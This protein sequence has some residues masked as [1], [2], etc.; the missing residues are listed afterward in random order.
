MS[1]IKI[2]K[3][4]VETEE[5]LRAKLRAMIAAESIQISFSNGTL[6]WGDSTMLDQPE[7]T[8]EQIA[9]FRIA[10]KKYQAEAAQRQAEALE[11][12]RLIEEAEAAEAEED[13]K[14]LEASWAS[15]DWWA[16]NRCTCTM[17]EVDSLPMNSDIPCL[18]YKRVHL[19]EDGEPEEC[20]FFNSPAGCRDGEHCVYQH[21]TRNPAEMPCRFES[22]SAGCNPGFG[23]KCPYMH[24]KPIVEASE[25]AMCRFDT[26][27]KPSAGKTCPFKH[28]NTAH[29]HEDGWTRSGKSSCGWR[30]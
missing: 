2:N 17:E 8:P 13:R 27:C 1:S 30:K 29:T 6:K 5:V 7:E 19:T 9:A 22:S 18:C 3:N 15:E 14:Y 12:K 28:S 4:I 25:P 21:V 10:Q 16:M 23:R 26:R 11:A 24:S 20:R